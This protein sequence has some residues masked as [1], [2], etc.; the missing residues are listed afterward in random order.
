VIIRD[1][2][3]EGF[4]QKK[5]NTM[6]T[7]APITSQTASQPGIQTR[8]PLSLTA[9]GQTVAGKAALVLGA[10][11]LVAVCAHFTV[12]LPFTPVP[13]TLGDLA[14][15]LVGLALGPQMAFAALAL[16]LAEGAA[17]LPVFAPNGMPG[18]AHLLG[19]TGGYLFAYP[20]AAA[21]A[22]FLARSLKRLPDYA[23]ALSAACSASLLIM[24][25]GAGWL[26]LSLHHSAAL[27]LQLAVLPFLPGQ[28]VKI[29]S[30]AGIYSAL[31]SRRRA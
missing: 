30:A 5:G 7:A 9:I 22:G 31:R 25:S 4:H 27:T 20:F 8:R 21:V 24:A 3:P 13:L 16:Y 6:Q 15:L 26:S 10:S 1:T 12:P 14:V 18:L 23:A 11:L 29:V 28:V 17:G 2:I 19:P